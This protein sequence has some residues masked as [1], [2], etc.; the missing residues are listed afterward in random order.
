[1]EVIVA[2]DGAA[3]A[4]AAAATFDW[5]NWRIV[6]YPLQYYYWISIFRQR[7]LDRI[8]PYVL[9]RWI[10]TAVLA[11]IYAFRI[12]IRGFCIWKKTLSFDTCCALQQRNI[13]KD[14]R[15]SGIELALRVS[16]RQLIQDYGMTGD[17]VS[18]NW[19]NR[20]NM[21]YHIGDIVTVM[22]V[23]VDSGVSG[24]NVTLL[25]VSSWRC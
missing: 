4:E 13:G 15:A 19:H 22:M 23:A 24:C 5:K 10:G 21:I 11:I 7:C 25:D 16:C 18:I 2:D 9:Y 20:P 14:I 12:Y 1:M 8:S 3:L 17:T 6:S